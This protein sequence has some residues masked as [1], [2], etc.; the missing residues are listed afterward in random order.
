VHLLHVQGK[1]QHNGTTFLSSAPPRFLQAPTL[2]WLMARC[3]SSGACW[4]KLTSRT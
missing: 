4:L 3:M 1:Q 2:S